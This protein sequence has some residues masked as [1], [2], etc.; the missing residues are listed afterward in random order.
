[1]GRWQV[2]RCGAGRELRRVPLDFDAPLKEVWSGYVMPD[3]LRLPTCSA[4]DGTGYSPE[5]KAV[6]DTFYPHMIGGPRADALAWH[7]KIGQAEVDNLVEAGRLWDFTR[8]VGRDGWEDND[9]PTHPTAAD[10][11]AWEG[12]GGLVGHDAINRGILV[13]FRCERLGIAVKCPVCEGHG[14]VGTPEQREAYEAWE[15]TQPPEGEGYQLWETTSEGSPVTPVFDTL[16]ALC[17]YAAD[18]CTTFGSSRVSVA[19]W[20]RMLSDDGMVIVD[21]TMPN[22]QR[23]SFI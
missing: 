14:S 16:D 2:S 15:W 8:H 18:N 5:A 7:N 1:M 12:R 9:P 20:R 10:V 4:C 23:V 21:E 13:R 6:A 17:E 22:G 11:N 3:D 19:E